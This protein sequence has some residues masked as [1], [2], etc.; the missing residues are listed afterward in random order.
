M[1]WKIMIPIYRLWLHSLYGLYGPQ[2]LLSPKRPLHL[3]TH[4]LHKWK[5]LLHRLTRDKKSLFAVTH[6][7]FYKSCPN[8]W[9]MGC[10]FFFRMFGKIDHVIVPPHCILDYMGV[11]TVTCL[12][13]LDTCV[14]YWVQTMPHKQCIGY[15][16]FVYN[17]QAL[18]PD[19]SGQFWYD[20]IKSTAVVHLT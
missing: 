11:Q 4:S 3:I 16:A 15:E 1:W 20:I 5:P 12:L 9:D 6:T 2:C 7:S 18:C 17:L 8:R 19:H 10:L 14:L 13:S